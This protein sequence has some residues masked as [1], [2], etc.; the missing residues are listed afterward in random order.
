[1][2]HPLIE[3]KLYLPSPRAGLVARPRLRQRLG[4]GLSA[5]LLLVSA[6]AGFGKTTV[7]VDWL[8]SLQTGD[9]AGVRAA[10]LSL[11]PRDNDPSRFWLYL[12]SALRTAV[13]GV[14]EDALALLGDSQAPPAETLLTTVVND[15]A[16]AEAEVVLL[17]DD[18]HVIDSPAVHEGMAFLLA[19]LPPRLHLVLASRVDPPL[20]LARLRARGE[21]VEV[22]AADLRFTA[23][24]AFTYLNDVMGID[25]AP[26]DVRALEGRTEGWIAALQLAALSMT[27]RDDIREFIAGFTGDDRYVVDYLVEEVLQRLPA[28]LQHFLHHTSILDRMTGTLCDAVTLGSG[29]RAALERL[30]RDNLFVVA[31][32]DRRHWYRY[33]HL[34]A[35]VLRGRLLDEEPALVPELHRRAAAWHEAH[36]DV[37]DAI[38]HSLAGADHDRAAVL[39]ESVMPALRRERREA[40][41][42]GWMEALADPVLRARP[43]LA[44]ALAGTRMSTGVFEGVEELLAATEQSLEAAAG[45]GGV[46]AYVDADEYRRLPADVAVHRAGLAL[47]RGDVEGTVEHSRRALEQAQDSDHGVRGA[48]LALGG[49]AAWTTGDVHG[50][51]DAYTACLAEFEAIDHVP[52]VLGCSVALGDM[53]VALG[54]PRQ[55]ARTYLAALDLADR[56]HTPVLRG[57]P[58]MHVGIAARHLEMEDLAAARR[59]LDRARDLPKHGWLPQFAFRWRVV[60][61]S[62][63]EAEGDV[64]AAVDLL[65]EAERRYVADFLPNVSPVAAVRARTWARHGHIDQ[66]LQWVDHVEISLDDSPTY[67][68]EYEHLTLVKV[69]LAAHEHGRGGADLDAAA[70]LLDRLLTAAHRA[71]RAGSVLEIEATRALVLHETG[72]PERAVDALIAALDLA[73][74][75]GYVR[76]FTIEGDAMARLLTAAEQRRPSPYVTRLRAAFTSTAP[77]PVGSAPVRGAPVLVDALS[78]REQDVLRLLNTELNG[79]DIARELVVSLNTVRTH[80]KNLYM[81]LGVTSRRAAVARARELNLL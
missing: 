62:V 79:P 70:V 56:H 40:T 3:T 80:T 13:P 19:H 16:A 9:D 8:A 10:W 61:A 27:G 53:E 55:A 50:A 4:A 11:D 66:A 74:P 41:L 28:D 42:R 60:A 71:R 7:L 33:H 49:L 52:D 45:P 32:D 44:N 5:R 57:R 75:E 81:K 67:L 43:V 17:L 21:L 78:G 51:H 37:A 73:E 6:P 39:I 68:R 18:Y 15:V 14:A 31:L 30:D 34:F 58:D 38:G 47:E 76:T 64:S 69:L 36:G 35:D 48:A 59:E 65:D 46:P 26:D 2:S 29:G 20:P 12:V 24:E 23:E 72:D 22:R 54:R 77:P 63:R 1:M 25:L